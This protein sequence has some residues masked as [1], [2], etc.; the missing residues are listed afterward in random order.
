MKKYL[1]FSI[2]LI[3]VIL[4][5][6]GSGAANAEGNGNINLDLQQQQG[7]AIITT[8]DMAVSIETKGNV[9]K[10]SFY[11]LS[12]NDTRFH[13]HFVKIMEFND[14]NGD[15]EFNESEHVPGTPALALSSVTWNLSDYTTEGTVYTFNYSSF[16]TSHGSGSN[17]Y[18]NFTINLVIHFD[19]TNGTA[20]KF[21]IA[22]ENWPFQDTENMLALRWD[23]TWGA[24]DNDSFSVDSRED[25][26]YLVKDS[27]D[28]AYFVYE[29]TAQI[30]ETDVDVKISYDDKMGDSEFTHGIKVFLSYPNFNGSKLYHDPTV[31]VVT[32]EDQETAETSEGI[33]TFLPFPT[34]SKAGF[35][36]ITVASSL[37]LVVGLVIRKKFK[38]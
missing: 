2:G 27:E 23:L 9:P 3:L 4:F 12:D 34:I 19:S 6:L 26:A 37:L 1:A 36:A 24:N 20:F 31:G 15:G 25:G 11:E 29:D 32:V 35:L 22:M 8:D 18:E 33:I 17:P 28:M 14:S 10:F 16:D 30:D 21:D 5:T 13:I 38:E 7:K